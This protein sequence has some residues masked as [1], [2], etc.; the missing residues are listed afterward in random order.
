MQHRL[1]STFRI[2]SWPRPICG[3]PPPCKGFSQ[4]FDQIACVHMS[5]LLVR[6]HM[7]AGQDGFRDPGSK[8]QCDQ[9]EGHW[10]YR[11]VPRRGSI[12]RTICSFLASSGIGSARLHSSCSPCLANL[13]AVPAE[14]GGHGFRRMGLAC[15]YRLPPDG[16]RLHRPRDEHRMALRNGSQWKP[17]QAW[18]GGRAETVVAVIGPGGGARD[19]V[20]TSGQSGAGRSLYTTRCPPG[21][22]AWISRYNSPLSSSSSKRYARSCWPAPPRPISTTCA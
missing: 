11:S 14:E 19:V 4:T 10:V 20:T 16:R 15:R 5:G 2:S 21:R 8:Q 22:R 17:T 1:S 3:R 9:R 6:S 7:N 13:W 12:D 18:S